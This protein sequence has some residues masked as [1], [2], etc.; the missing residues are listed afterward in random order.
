MDSAEY[1]QLSKRLGEQEA[2]LDDYRHKQTAL[3]GRFTDFFWTSAAFA[4]LVFMR[5]QY[6]TDG[7]ASALFGTVE[8]IGALGVIYL[9]VHAIRAGVN[10]P[11]KQSSSRAVAR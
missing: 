9:A 3:E 11:K 1:E 6:R 4:V 7:L 10:S 2:L 5:V 8:I